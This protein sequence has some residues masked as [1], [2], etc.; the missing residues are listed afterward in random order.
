MPTSSIR[1]L[2]RFLRKERAG[3][4]GPDATDGALLARYLAQRD[5]AAFEILLERHVAMGLGVCQR[6]VGDRHAG[7][8]P[9]QATVLVLC[10]RAGSMRDH[11]SRGRCRYVVA[12][13]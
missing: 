7:E 13:P 12:Q 9:F 6:V 10:H 11:G 4:E 5:E 2:L 1:D 8:D 3:L